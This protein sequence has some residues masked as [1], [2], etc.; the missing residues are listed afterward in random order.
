M[1][2]NTEGKN[3]L[4]TVCEERTKNYLNA[5]EILSQSTDDFLFLF[6]ISSDK[7][8]FFGEIDEVYNLCNKGEATISI[9]Q[10]LNIVYPSDRAPLKRDLDEIRQGK[11]EFHD[12]EYRLVDNNGNSVWVSSR[13]KVVQ[14]GN[15]IIMIGR[16]SEEALRPYFNPLTG[17]FNKFKMMTDLKNDFRKATSGYFMLV[18]IDNLAAINLTHGRK[19]GD[20][21]LKIL[22]STIE[23]N[24][25]TQKLYHVDHNYFAVWLNSQTEQDVLD[26]Y[27]QLQTAMTGKCTISAGI[28]PFD[29]NVFI[30]ENSLYDSAKITLR[31]AKNKG[32]SSLAFFSEEELKNKLFSIELL[33]E[34]HASVKNNF[35]GFYLNFQPQ[36]KAGSYH[37]FAAEALIR[38]NSKAH[39]K[40]FPNDFIPL[41][42]QSRLIYDVGLWGLETALLQCKVWRRYIKDFRISVNFSTVQFKNDNIVEDVL[43]VLKKTQM[44]GDALTIELTES[45]PLNEIDHFI[46][47]IKHLKTHDIQFSIDDFGTGYSN[48]GYLKQLDIDEIKFDRMFINGIE[49]DTYN[50]K[51]MAN[52]IE[53]AKANSIRICCEGVEYEKELAV[54][55]TLSP[56]TLQG[57]LFDK[58][59]HPDEIEL[60]YFD[61]QAMEYK[62]RLDFIIELYIYNEKM[63][64]IRF[65]P[66]DILRETDV[67]LW[68]IRINEKEGYC[69]LHT[70]ETMERIMSVG[71]KYTP[72][73]CYEFWYS[74]IHKDYIDYVQKNIR[75]MTEL[76]K[77]VQLQYPWIHPKFG[78]VIVRSTGKRVKDYDGMIVIEGYHRIFSNIEE[79]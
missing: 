79:V 45:I 46:N 18:D 6:D 4:N 22:A 74:R 69:E 63:G 50:Y 21:V 35:E 14:D 51:L 54:L 3:K 66:K 15:S 43:S 10:M 2:I 76:K 29:K 42:E 25:S 32:E 59:S 37:I 39:G 41:L 36:V 34:L 70:D 71:K 57:Y 75:L 8:W 23:T 61:T 19:Y 27:T 62:K 72:Q 47:I 13:G 67:G 55:E 9:E 44:P 31:K 40:V 7:I 20:D 60:T 58:P 24:S 77:P 48:L 65:N 5:L 1:S 78:E 33:E 11:K 52:T 53:F 30:D 16:V 49:E 73:E 56:D 12:M 68:I 17:L 38:Y 28:V 26:V 64:V